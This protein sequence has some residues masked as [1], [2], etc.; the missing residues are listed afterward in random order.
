MSIANYRK[1]Y[2]KSKIHNL[3]TALAKLRKTHKTAADKNAE[4]W[5]EVDYLRLTR[6]P[7]LLDEMGITSVKL[8]GIGT[9]GTRFEASCST[10]DKEAL[11]KWLRKHGYEDLI[12]TDT[13]NSSTLKSFITNQIRDK[14]KIPPAKIVKYTPFEMAV[15]TK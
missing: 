7:E 6:I 9:L 15:I 2:A 14:E 10:Q 4:V 11:L 5:A 1:K 12:A 8:K 3:G 13:V